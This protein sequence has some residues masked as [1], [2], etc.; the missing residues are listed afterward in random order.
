MNTGNLGSE[1]KVKFHEELR[2]F[3]SRYG[4]V[5]FFYVGVDLMGDDWMGYRCGA[6]DQPSHS[7]RHR[8]QR[9]TGAIEGLK[10]DLNTNNN[11]ERG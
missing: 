6:S 1:G 9:L 4:V 10:I 5:D 7:N 8:N 11:Y 2:A 3:F